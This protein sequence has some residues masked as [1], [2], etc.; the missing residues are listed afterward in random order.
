M[1]R[2]RKGVS[3]Y[4]R[5]AVWRAFGGICGLC[6]EPVDYD[7][8]HIDHIVQKAGGGP[9]HVLNYRPVHISCNLQRPRYREARKILR[10]QFK[11]LPESKLRAVMKELG[12]RGGKARAANLTPEER[13]II[14]EKGGKAARARFDACTHERQEQRQ[15]GTELRTYCI[16]CRRRLARSTQPA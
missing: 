7:N 1:A 9:D 11:K 14:A 6:D 13:H 8:M 12:A 16:S 2:H 5:E 10:K 3:R 4:E 15:I